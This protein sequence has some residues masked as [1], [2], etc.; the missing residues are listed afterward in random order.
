M[1]KPPEIFVTARLTGRPPR[2]A[3]AEAAFAAYASDPEVTRYLSWPAYR[4]IE[5]LRAFL[6]EARAHWE[7]GDGSYAW[8][9][10][11]KGTDQPIGSIGV[12]LDDGKALF[13]YV[14][15]RKFWGRGLMTEALQC[16]ADWA[17]SSRKSGGCGRSATWKTRGR[18]A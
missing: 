12:T 3:D 7:K 5:P 16:L 18:P 9:L 17:G 6:A 14:L 8:M 2:V 15:A 11:L 4:R 13:G 10:S 1:L